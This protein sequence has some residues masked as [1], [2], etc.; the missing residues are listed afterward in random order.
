MTADRSSSR[1]L[2]VVARERIVLGAM[3]VAGAAWL[4]QVLSAHRLAVAIAGAGA[5]T[6]AVAL[7][8]A[9]LGAGAAAAGRARG[10]ARLLAGLLAAAAVAGALGLPVAASLGSAV[11]AGATALLAALLVGGSAGAAAQLLARQAG[12]AAGRLGA[13][14]C[15]GGALGGAVGGFWLVWSA[16]VTGAALLASGFELAAAVAVWAACRRAPPDAG[17][18]GRDEPAPAA[19]GASRLAL[20]LAGASVATGALG[21]AR[22]LALAFGAT[23][24]TS[25]AV[26]TGLLVVVAAGAAL[27]ARARSER[28]AGLLGLAQLAS[29]AAM[30][31]VTP[32]LARLPYLGLRLR[33]ALWERPSGYALMLAAEAVCAALLLLVPAAAAGAALA[34]GPQLQARAAGGAGRVFGGSSAWLG[35][36]AALGAVLAGLLLAA[37]GV[38]AT[39]ETAVVLALAAAAPLLWPERRGSGA[40]RA[41]YLAAVTLA[42]LAAYLAGGRSFAERITLAVKHVRERRDLPPSFAEFVARYAIGRGLV[43]AAEDAHAVVAVNE[44][45]GARYLWV[46]GEP[47]ASNAGDL[48]AQ[49]GLAHYPLLLARQIR[50]VL[51]VGYGSGIPLGTALQHE[52]Q[53]ADVVEPSRAAIGAGT[54]FAE[55][56]HGALGDARVRLFE[57]DVRA[58]L[59]AAGRR[60]DVVV[61][62][63]PSPWRAGA[64]RAY[65]AE[66]FALLRQRLEPGGVAAIRLAG[67][68]QSDLSLGLLLRTLRSALPHVEI[69]GR[70][71]A[72]ELL[73]VAAAEPVTVDFAA[74]ER[75][76]GRPGVRRDLG[77]V[78]V[79]NLASLLAHHLVPAARVAALGG[80]GPVERDGRGSLERR[81]QLDFFRAGS[82]GLL[83]DSPAKGKAD[84]LSGALL[85]RY[86]AFLERSGRPLTRLDYANVVQ[87]LARSLSAGAPAIAAIDARVR[88]AS[89]LSF[90]GATSAIYELEYQRAIEQH[91]GGSPAAAI[92]AYEAALR[93]APAEREART[94]LAIALREAGRPDVAR[95]ELERLVHDEPQYV[96]P[97]VELGLLY[98]QAGALGRAAE[99]YR[100]ALGLRPH[101]QAA[102]NLAA[103]AVA[104]GELG[105]AER[106]YL[107]AL[108]ADPG[109][110]WATLGLGVLRWQRLADT[111]GALEALRAGLA[112]SP[113]DGDMQRLV[114]QIEAASRAGAPPPAAPAPPAPPPA[115]PAPTG[116]TR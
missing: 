109:Y 91:R 102:T 53:R 74:M 78:G 22:L 89:E 68:A 51:V 5:G 85:D 92:P 106:H 83:R 39:Y 49:L 21:V 45:E 14:L 65:T 2:S 30:M 6:T 105:E 97:L 10:S 99:L 38:L 37:S 79:Y 27:G 3:F 67:F 60:Y 48:D 46:D 70:H 18:G 34:L 47:E 100:R 44:I 24:D 15:A 1:V 101:A 90:G 12:T 32:L 56:N 87:H 73:L 17:S 59:G 23:A 43:Y 8:L 84:V 26:L 54:A 61:Y 80:E 94:N 71:L 35:A 33:G 116:P 64:G 41:G 29:A 7:V 63:P 13:V 115:P 110:R 25:V 66:L 108:R 75:R 82:A 19:R 112:R 95:T 107:E 111:P 50:S 81:A 98:Q 28:P 4:V 88:S 93:I 69:F 77:R 31:A 55:Q 42:V 114:A 96:E 62:Q 113:T 76:F 11:V 9:G 103:I 72:G 86:A 58:F 57:A 16:G 20:L 104:R 36:G 40:R 52:V